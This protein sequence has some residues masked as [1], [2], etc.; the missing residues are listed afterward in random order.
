MLNLHPIVIY[1]DLFNYIT[2]PFINKY[3]LLK[4]GVM[5]QSTNFKEIGLL[6]INFF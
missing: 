6:C 3:V 4:Y 2:K 5:L 1:S